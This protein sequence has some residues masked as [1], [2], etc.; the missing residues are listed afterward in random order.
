MTWGRDVTGTSRAHHKK[1]DPNPEKKGQVQDQPSALSVAKKANFKRSHEGPSGNRGPRGICRQ[2]RGRSPKSKRHVGCSGATRVSRPGGGGIARP[3]S[4]RGSLSPSRGTERPKQN[5][6]T[7]RG[8]KEKNRGGATQGGQNK[9]Q[10]S[11]GDGRRSFYKIERS[12]EENKQEGTE[13]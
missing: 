11:K 9:S 12:R 1:N 8:N 7:S 2:R 10:G 3:D 4:P 6:K 13:R 5:N